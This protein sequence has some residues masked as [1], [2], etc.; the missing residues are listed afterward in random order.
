M[1]PGVQALGILFCV[2]MLYVTYVQYRRKNYGYKS[3]ILWAAVWIAAIVVVSLPKTVYGIMQALEIQRTAD[4]FVLIGF[5]FFAAITF[6]MYAMVR[7]N[8]EKLEKL[9][10]NLA[11]ENKDVKNKSE[12][13]S[14]MKRKRK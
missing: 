8:N 1:I 7:K 6:Y 4:F 5:A 14:D 11:V 10:R 9:V 13:K 3:L 2:I 12:S